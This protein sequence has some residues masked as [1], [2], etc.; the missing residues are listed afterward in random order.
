MLINR[1]FSVIH[2]FRLSEGSY[3]R[4]NRELDYLFDS[5]IPS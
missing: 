1:T 5:L 4:D 2:I 3:G